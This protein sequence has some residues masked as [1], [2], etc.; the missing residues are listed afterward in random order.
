MRS[1]DVCRGVSLCPAPRDMTHQAAD[2]QPGS[3]KT[4]DA[5]ET[6]SP[7]GDS[8]VSGL[9]S[10]EQLVICW[11]RIC[12]REFGPDVKRIKSGRHRC[13]DCDNIDRALHYYFHPPK[14]KAKPKPE[15]LVIV[16][17]RPVA[18]STHGGRRHWGES[19]NSAKLTDADIPVIRAAVAD[20]ASFHSI[21]RR[22]HVSDPTI[23]Q[24]ALRRS[25]K[26]VA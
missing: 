20:G 24:A 4:S 16:R 22:Y 15:P 7:P 19:V 2:S 14:S 12:D 8:V 26:H 11:C 17:P 9:V 1:R 3:A 23:K 6:P 10:D 18:K 13:K 25:W 21:A 5:T